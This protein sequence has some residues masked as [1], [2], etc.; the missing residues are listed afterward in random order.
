M[1]SLPGRDIRMNRGGEPLPSARKVRTELHS[2]GR[3]EDKVTFNAAAVHMLEFINR[4]ISIMDGPRKM[5]LWYLYYYLFII[6]LKT[7]LV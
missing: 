5:P 3:V 6:N 7:V 1:A 4:D 2:T